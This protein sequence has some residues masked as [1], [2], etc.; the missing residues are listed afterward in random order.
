MINEINKYNLIGMELLF[1]ALNNK[2]SVQ[3]P[4]KCR[5]RFDENR[6]GNGLRINLKIIKSIF[7]GIYLKN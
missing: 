4:I 6:F 7:K 5:E 2:L 3:V 1:I